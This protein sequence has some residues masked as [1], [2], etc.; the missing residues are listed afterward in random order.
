[1][2]QEI[3]ENPSTTDKPNSFEDAFTRLEA[4]VRQL[5]SGQLS[6]DKSVE[7]FE[8]GM[9]L[10]KTCSEMLNKAEL[11]ISK[12]REDYGLPNSGAPNPSHSANP[13]ASDDELEKLPW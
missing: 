6:L 10:S 8:E 12:L 2:S 7:L 3:K 1:M 11:K 5:E 4:V 9:S 13:T